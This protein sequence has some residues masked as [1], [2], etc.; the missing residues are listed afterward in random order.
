MAQSKK[1]PDLPEL[2]RQIKENCLKPLYLFYGTETFLKETYIKAI[3]NAVPDNGFEEFNH[4]TLKGTD[5]PLSEY[6]D[7]WESFPMMAEKKLLYIS[8][9]G[10]FKSATE[11]QKEFWKEKFLRCPDD[12]VVIFDE[13]EIDKRGVIY[14]AFAKNGMAVKFETPNYA[15]LVTFV[16]GRC[17]RAHKKIRR[18]NAQHFVMMCDDNLQ[19]IVNELEKLF[20]YCDSEITKSDIDKVVS[21]SLSVRIFDLTDGIITHDAKKAME[22][23]TELRNS[24]EKEFQVLYLIHSN[25]K[26]LLQTKL[27]GNTNPQAV[28]SAIGIKNSYIVQKYISGA[29]GFSEGALAKMLI[30]IPEID[31]QIKLG[32]TDAWTALE[33]YVAEALYYN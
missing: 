7:A 12:M 10:I 6:D 29:A 15:D 25:V 9:S 19:S 22:I 33:Q 3:R 24:N 27:L 31:Y 11:E 30:R 32:K 14:K 5:V 16:T 8:G 26:K 18:E 4:I 23:L 13:T 1:N 20:D 17:L 28:A 2:K 21:K